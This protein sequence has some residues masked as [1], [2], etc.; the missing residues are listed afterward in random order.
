MV[1]VK[2]GEFFMGYNKAKIVCHP[3]ETPALLVKLSDFHVSQ[4]EITFA[5]YDLFCESKG[6]LYSGSNDLIEVAWFATPKGDQNDKLS[7]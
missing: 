5:Q 2:G 1:E 4:Y 7:I 3:D 6:F